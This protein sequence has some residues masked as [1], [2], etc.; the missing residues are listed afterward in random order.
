MSGR[1][2]LIVTVAV[3]TG[4]C[5]RDEAVRCSAGTRYLAAESAGLLRVPD[6]LTVPEQ[7][8]ALNIPAQTPPREADQDSLD[9][10]EYS[11]AFSAEEEEPEQD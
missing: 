9:C 7:S 2:L 8:E 5:S 1:W 3:L 10:L 4:A 6:D 11:P